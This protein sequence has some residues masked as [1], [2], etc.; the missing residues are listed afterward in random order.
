LSP[1]PSSP[2]PAP[3]PAQR[4]SPT[5]P[6]PARSTWG[7]DEDSEPPSPVYRAPGRLGHRSL[8]AGSKL[9]LVLGLVLSLCAPAMGL[10]P[11]AHPAAGTSGGASIGLA[12]T[13][14][15]AGSVTASITAPLAPLA[16]ASAPSPDLA[17]SLTDGPT[18][19]R[20]APPPAPAGS[21][22]AS[23]AILT[24]PVPADFAGTCTTTAYAVKDALA[25][26]S[27]KNNRLSLDPQ[28][29]IRSPSLPQECFTRMCSE[30]S[31][32]IGF[33]DAGACQS[34]PEV[35]LTAAPRSLLPTTTAVLTA[36]LAASPV[37]TTAYRMRTR[38]LAA[39]LFSD[40]DD[41]IA[42]TMAD[43]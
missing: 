22:A 28:H 17:A 5:R 12:P 32:A 40:D 26:T 1:P 42:P 38:R 11:S 37:V 23:A 34:T 25:F 39:Y 18:T 41:G 15:L 24:S 43:A 36:A 21:T 14:H 27:S 20:L 31:T 16:M 30:L 3:P 13:P 9:N 33:S 7:D 19:A 29:G 10:A 4:G 35:T 6:S 2:A 8:G